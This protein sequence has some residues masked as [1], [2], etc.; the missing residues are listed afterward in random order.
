MVARADERSEA[1]GRA[2]RTWRPAAAGDCGTDPLARTARS[3]ARGSGRHRSTNSSRRRRNECVLVVPGASRKEEIVG[4]TLT[5]L[6]CRRWSS[7]KPHPKAGRR[8]RSGPGGSSPEKTAATPKKTGRARST[9]SAVHRRQL[10]RWLHPHRTTPRCTPL[11]RADIRRRPI[12][13]APSTRS[14]HLPDFRAL[15]ALLQVLLFVYYT[16]IIFGVA[17]PTCEGPHMIDVILR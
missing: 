12:S 14:P 10:A 13:R 7:C 5:E 16:E 4:Q 11:R 2:L 6:P 9:S 15:R 3:A 17:S 8:A 1:G